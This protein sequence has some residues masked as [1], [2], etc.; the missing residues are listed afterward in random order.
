MPLEK[1]QWCFP[2]RPNRLYNIASG[3]T[4]AGVGT[5]AKVLLAWLNKVNCYNIELLESAVSRRNKNQPLVTVSNH[6]S[7][8]DDPSIWGCLRIKTLFTR[9]Y[10]RWTLAANDIVFTRRLY[11]K[12]FSLGRCVPVCRGDGVYQ[13]GVDFCLQKLNNGDWVHVFPEGKVN[14]TNEYIR[15]KWG[16]GRLIAECKQVPLVIPFWH[17]GMEDVLPNKEPYIPHI[18]KTVTLLVGK[19]IEF[20]DMLTHLRNE[21]RSPLE[22]RKKITDI[23]QEEFVLLKAKAEALHHKALQDRQGFQSN[24]INI[25]N[26]EKANR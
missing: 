18:G 13:Q 3:I 1:F 6:R 21:R 17:V 5:F 14:M 11:S 12:F 19:P 26:E 10:M 16:V 22:I 15:L 4:I 7:C 24:N 8:L 25:S 2:A 23:I 20:R 9:K